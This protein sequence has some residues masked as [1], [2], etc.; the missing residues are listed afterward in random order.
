MEFTFEYRL[1]IGLH[2]LTGNF[3]YISDA[4]F[5]AF[6]HSIDVRSDQFDLM[7]FDLSCI[8]GL[9]QLEAIHT[10]AVELYLHITAADDLAFECRCECNR[11]I[12]MSN[13]DFD[14]SC[15]QGGCIEFSNIFLNDKALWY[16]SVYGIHGCSIVCDDREAKCDSSCAA[17]NDDSIQ[18][19]KCVYECRHTFFG[20]CHKTCSIAWLNVTK[21]QSCTD[22]NRY[23]MNNGSYVFAQRDHTYIR[24][25]LVTQF[26]TLVN[27]AA[28]QGNQDTLCLIG[29][30][31]INT[32][33]CSRSGTKDNCNTRDITCNKGYTKFTDNSISKMSVA[34]SVVRS[35][36]IHILQCFNKFCTKSCSNTA[37]KCII[38]LL[39][40]GHKGFYNPHSC[41]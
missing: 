29:F 18:R 35:S 6:R 26:F 1:E 15:F 9:Y 24:A 7:I 34:G 37:H 14:I 11:N 40:S 25:G 5:A 17:C 28:Y 3:Y 12:D 21:D 23:Y 19:C 13:F 33:L 32:F 22:G 16:T 27:N 4:L 8:L 38:Q 36:T 39:F 2:G 10:R 31:K 20:I 30:Y 41:F